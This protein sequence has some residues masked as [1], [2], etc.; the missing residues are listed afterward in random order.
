MNLMSV[1]EFTKLKRVTD[2][3]TVNEYVMF[4]DWIPTLGMFVTTDEDG[5]FMEKPLRKFKN[6][7]NP[8]AFGSYHCGFCGYNGALTPESIS[9]NCVYDEYQKRSRLLVFKN[10]VVDDYG[11]DYVA[12]TDGSCYL[13]F[14]SNGDIEDRSDEEGNFVTTI[15]GLIE[16]DLELMYSW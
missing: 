13:I 9:H 3:H 16:Y 4:T 15:E 7:I 12:V 8:D 11:E 1:K 10:F 14:H 5:T 2:F 6:T